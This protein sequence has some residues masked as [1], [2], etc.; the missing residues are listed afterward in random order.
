MV[1]SKPWNYFEFLQEDKSKK[2]KF[3]FCW[4]VSPSFLIITQSLSHSLS[5]NLSLSISLFH[6]KYLS[7]SVSMPAPSLY[8]SQHARVSA[9]GHITILSWQR[10]S[11]RMLVRIV[12]AAAVA[13]TFRRD[14]TKCFLFCW[15]HIILIRNNRIYFYNI[16][17]VLHNTNIGYLLLTRCHLTKKIYPLVIRVE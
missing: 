8:L 14:R 9:R 10:F 15:Q 17:N 12:D 6:S 7:L 5:R 16:L 4:I 2:T 3:R 1:Y 11:P 13:K